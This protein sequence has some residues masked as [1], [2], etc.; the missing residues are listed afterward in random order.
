VKIKFLNKKW[1]YKTMGRTAINES[2]EQRL[3]KRGRNGYSK[4]VQVKRSGH[5]ELDFFQSMGRFSTALSLC[6]VLSAAHYFFESPNVSEVV[7]A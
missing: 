6:R 3:D 4:R 7:A 5:V 1:I 2:S